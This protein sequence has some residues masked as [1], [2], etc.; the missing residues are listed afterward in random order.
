MSEG[1]DT[2]MLMETLN[3]LIEDRDNR[4]YLDELHYHT[5]LIHQKLGRVDLAEEHFI[6]SAHAMNAQQFQVGLSYEELG[7]IQFDRANYVAAGSYYD[8]VLQIP[9][10]IN[11]KRIRRL[12]RKR[13]NLEEVIYF[14]GISQTN[15]SILNVVDMTLE[16][17][18]V[19][20]Q[21]YIDQLIAKEAAGKRT[22]NKCR[23]WSW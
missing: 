4:P 22:V 7:N 13:I 3:K 14:E 8:S 10:D 5:G 16:E 15:D 17:Q 11:T 6:A 19:Y 20:F 9:Q 12:Q 2:Q 23:F 18:V 21:Y 1:S